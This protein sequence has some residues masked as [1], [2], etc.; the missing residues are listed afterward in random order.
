MQQYVC[1]TYVYVIIYHVNLLGTSPVTW[2]QL[3]NGKHSVTVR[4]RCIIDGI[5]YSATRIKIEFRVR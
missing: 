5:V 3:K 1:F 4:A 2:N